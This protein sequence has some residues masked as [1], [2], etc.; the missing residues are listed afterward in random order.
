MVSKLVLA[1]IEALAAGGAYAG[2][3][4]LSDET[5]A[6]VLSWLALL[7]HWNWEGAS[8]SLSPAETDTIDNMVAEA[9]TELMETVEVNGM[10]LGMIIAFAGDTIPDGWLFCDGATYTTDEYPDLYDALDDVFH[11]DWYY[12]NVPDLK[13][14]V[15]AGADDP[16]APGYEVGDTGGA[17]EV[18]LTEGEMPEHSH[19][20][21][22]GDGGAPVGDSIF[23]YQQAGVR[24][25][26]TDTRATGGDEAHENMP[27]FLA[28][29]WIIYA[30]E[31]L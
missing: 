30:G 26:W 11:I 4:T 15:V 13:N 8:Y 19:E 5:V 1:E 12:F 21:P 29:R 20:V 16:I 27:P 25:Y 31:S 23:R 6:L 18:I 22:Y 10:E 24:Y 7:F 17:A 3:Y 2:T 14:R 9:L 28:L